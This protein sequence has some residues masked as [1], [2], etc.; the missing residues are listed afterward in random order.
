MFVKKM[1]LAKFTDFGFF[2]HVWGVDLAAVF[3]AKLFTVHGVMF[4]GFDVFTTI[5]ASVF[6]GICF[7]SHP[8]Y[9]V[10]ILTVDKRK[11]FVNKKSRQRRPAGRSKPVSAAHVALL[12]A[13]SIRW[14]Q[15][16]LAG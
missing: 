1:K 5:F 14:P 11:K 15:L 12:D 7:W 8:K 13:S 10:H 9:F 2:L 6:F 4:A 16:Y 3:A